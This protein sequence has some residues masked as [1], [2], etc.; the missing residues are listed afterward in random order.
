MVADSSLANYVD[1][2][3]S[4]EL[5]TADVLWLCEVWVKT[6]KTKI[7]SQ[8]DLHQ[9]CVLE[10]ERSRNIKRDGIHVKTCQYKY[11]CV[12]N[13]IHIIDVFIDR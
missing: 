4:S 1:I 7:R 12:S 9:G 10:P 6:T 11:K 5:C 2:M 3:T 8:M 13:S